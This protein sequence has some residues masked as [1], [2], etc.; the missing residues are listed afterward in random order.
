MCNL[1]IPEEP[2]TFT[3]ATPAGTWEF[4]RLP[5]YLERKDDILCHSMCGMTYEAYKTVDIVGSR[6]AALEESLNELLPLCLGASYLTAM[7]VAP[8]GGIPGSEVSLVQV[9][10]HFPRVRGM[11]S[12]RHTALNLADFKADMESFVPA[13]MRV[14]NVEKARLLIHHWLDALA[15]WSLEGLVLST[16]TLLEVIAATAEDSTQRSLDTFATRIEF[17]ARRFGLR[18]LNPNFRKMRNDLIHE[19]TLSGRRLP[20]ATVEDC[21]AL[22]ADTLNWIDLYLHA[23]FGLGSPRAARFDRSVFQEGV[24]AFSLD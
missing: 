6:S 10:D 4:R 14:E 12:G 7:T 13:Y 2:E 16:T 22:A 17:A 15:F 11:G 1:F 21:V 24:N 8:D 5:G 19:G 23:I 18:P 9:A 20:N 3:L